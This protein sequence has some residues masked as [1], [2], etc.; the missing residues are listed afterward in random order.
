MEGL[1]RIVREHPF[2]AGLDESF[3]ELV[4][5]CAR[6]VR[7]EAGKYLFREG[8]PADQLYL[9]REGRVALEIAAPG[10]GAIT[11]Q[12]VAEGDIVGV[13]W[14]FPP[15]RWQYDAHALERVRAIAMDATCLRNKCDADP[16]LGYDVM[17]RL[18]P[19]LYQRLQATRLQVLDVYGKPAA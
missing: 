11:F 19:I 2:F 5:G 13:S 14:L 16:G 4:V 12:T 15:Y 9:V 10:A 8:G 18:V 3:L 7:F 6:N 1:E 17:K